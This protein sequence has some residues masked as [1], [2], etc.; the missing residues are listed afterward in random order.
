MNNT[1]IWFVPAVAVT[2][3]IFLL[4]TFLAIPVQVEEIGYLDKLE[5]CFAYSALIISFL[6]A[7]R[8]ADLLSVRRSYWLLLF[9]SIYGLLLELAQ[10][11]FFPNRFFEWLDAA[12]N[13]VGVLIGFGI[14]K[15]FDRG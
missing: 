9:A 4:S 6:I 8:K 5:H 7:F 14:F 1:T 15:L 3:G 10:Y 13:V 12:S 11:T 2:L